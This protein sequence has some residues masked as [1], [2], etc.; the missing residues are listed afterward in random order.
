LRP[1]RATR[2]EATWAAE[3]GTPALCIASSGE[4]NRTAIHGERKAGDPI[5]LISRED[6]ADAAVRDGGMHAGDLEQRA[7]TLP[8]KDPPY[9][10]TSIDD[11]EGDTALVDRDLPGVAL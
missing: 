11:A 9:R 8:S 10:I 5:L 4:E 1:S 2:P 3:A 7:A 6:A